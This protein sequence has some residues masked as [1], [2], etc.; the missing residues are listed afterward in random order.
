MLPVFLNMACEVVENGLPP[1]ALFLDRIG[2]LTI[3]GYAHSYA[4]RAIC[5]LDLCCAI[6]E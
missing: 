5:E 1:I 2:M 4:I 6:S 3:E